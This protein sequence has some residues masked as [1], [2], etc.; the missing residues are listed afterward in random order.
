[1]RFAQSGPGRSVAVTGRVSI[2]PAS[3][4]RVCGFYSRAGTSKLANAGSIDGPPADA[5][6]TCAKSILRMARRSDHGNLAGPSACVRRETGRHHILPLG[7]NAGAFG[8]NELR[9]KD[10]TRAPSRLPRRTEFS[11][12]PPEPPQGPA[13]ASRAAPV[14]CSADVAGIAPPA[15]TTR[16]GTS[17]TAGGNHRRN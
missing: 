17:G 12:A 1:M 5:C 11:A 2:S 4:L 9:I 13:D 15:W 10:R 7:T 8:T 6:A 16:L 14:L 3:L